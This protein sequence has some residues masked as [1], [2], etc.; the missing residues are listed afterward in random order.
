MSIIAVSSAALA[1]RL[2]ITA[3]GIANY[4]ILARVLGQHGTGQYFLFVAVLLAFSL[5]AELGL[6]QSATV[7]AGR[8]NASPST[9]HR[10]LI[11]WAA[12]VGTAAGVVS[13][14]LLPILRERWIPDLP[15]DSLW[16]AAVALPFAIY[17][18]LWTGLAIG[19]ERVLTANAV[20]LASALLTLILTIISVVW[21]RGGV[22]AAI[23]VYVAVLAV[24]S[25]AMLALARR[26]SAGEQRADIS[27]ALSTDLIGFGLRGYTG[28]LSTLVWARSTLFV[29]DHFHGAAAVGAFSVAQQLAEKM[30]LPA[31][32]IKDVVYKRIA[33]ASRAEATD[34][35]NRYLRLITCGLIPLMLLGGWTA[36][37]VCAWIFG[38][39]F[40]AA[41]RPFQVLLL[42]TMVML[43]SIVL[44]PF[45]LSQL[46]RPG[47][48]SILAWVNGVVNV[49]LALLLVPR[50]GVI[51]AAL[52]MLCTQVLGTVIVFFMYLR[53]APTRFVGTTQ[54][55]THDL[56]LVFS[57]F[58]AL[59]G[60]GGQR[61]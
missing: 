37:Y 47:L 22:P 46:N 24:Q 38:P 17:A 7:F 53:L 59:V 5:V 12:G 34:M 6:S 14:L 9:I 50:M 30:L 27:K 51:G 58:A 61:K 18:N 4:A 25:V 44:I 11:G 55:S 60:L 36:P 35:T 43:V 13:M 15:E 45:F 23:S 57:E 54:L 31:H 19:M 16:L 10:F 40:A 48:L 41:A 1:F 21:L 56:A 20:Q 42:G 33:S 49:S 3:L 39:Q 26:F 8:K 28:A 29:L 32:I 2:A 52:A